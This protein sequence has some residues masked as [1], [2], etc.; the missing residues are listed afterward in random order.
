MTSHIEILKL[1][2]RRLQEY[3]KKVTKRF[4]QQKTESED[5]S[6]SLQKVRICS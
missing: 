6:T 5:M 3:N 1:E 4:G 2:N